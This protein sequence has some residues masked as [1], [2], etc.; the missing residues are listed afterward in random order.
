[1]LKRIEQTLFVNKPRIQGLKLV[2]AIAGV[3]ALAVASILLLNNVVAT[4]I[5]PRDAAIRGWVNELA[6]ERLTVERQR[7]QA[8]LEKAGEEA[9]P[10]LTTALH[11]Q[12]VNTRINAATVLGFIGSPNSTAALVN[13]LATDPVVTVRANAAF[14]LGEIRDAAALSTLQDVSV[15]ETAPQVRSIAA[16]AL[17]KVNAAL[18][19]RAGRDLG[20]VN[21]VAPSVSQPGT[22]YLASQRDLLISRN[23]GA[24]WE[25]LTQALPSVAS[26]LAVNP[27]NPNVLYAGMHSNGMAVSTD[28]GNTW[29]SLTGNF[30]SEAIGQSTV[31]AVTVDPANAERVVMAHGIQIGN[32]GREFFPLGILYSNDGGKTWDNV[33]DLEDGQIVTRLQVRDGKVYALAGERV[34]VI[35]IA[36]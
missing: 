3:V 34:L 21:V 17:K 27:T 4:P 25:T 14:A 33:M 35:P 36:N 13:A 11:S 7:A 19:E 22:I 1:M 16:D 31:T 9:V 15:M 5:S 30:S 23:N 20:D 29:Q 32:T 12:D 26:S 8:E 2:G 6:S 10:A 28:G 18:I 24:E